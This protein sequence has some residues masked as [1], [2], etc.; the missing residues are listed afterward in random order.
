MIVAVAVFLLPLLA[1]MYLLVLIGACFG[2]GF[3]AFMPAL[4]A[5]VVDETTPKQRASALA[6]FTS[7]MDV[8]ITSGALILGVVGQY[9][10]F[11]TMFGLGGVIAVLGV[12]LFGLYGRATPT[13]NR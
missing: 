13:S 11:E 9:W 4:N 1:N 3:G 12:V 8:G 10:G 7:F 6:F 2:L 5:F